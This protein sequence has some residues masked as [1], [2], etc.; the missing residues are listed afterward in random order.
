EIDAKLAEL[1]DRLKAFSRQ[2]AETKAAAIL[3]GVH[4]KVRANAVK[5]VGP[6]NEENF[7]KAL[8]N[9]RLGDPEAIEFVKAVLGTSDA[10]GQAIVPNNFVAQLVT[11]M[12][13]TNIYR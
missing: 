12:A 3:A 7:L 1:D 2:Q 13:S 11:Q 4:D 8:V 9:R 10:T 5:A 6:Y